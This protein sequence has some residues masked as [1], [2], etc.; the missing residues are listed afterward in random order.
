MQNKRM[1]LWKQE[2]GRYTSRDTKYQICGVSQYKYLMYNEETI[3]N[4]RMINTIA[5]WLGF[6][7]FCH[8]QNEQ[9]C[10][11]M[12]MLIGFTIVTYFT[13]LL[14]TVCVR[15]KDD[16]V[17]KSTCFSCRRPRVHS[18]CQHRCSQ[19]SRSGDLLSSSGILKHC[20]CMVHW[21]TCRQNTSYTHMKVNCKIK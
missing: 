6:S 12:D 18:Q 1:V 20:V 21:Y 9:A 10:Q 14:K 2:M 11:M 7:C 13:V 3:L 15:D 5:K 4:N 16:S 8:I 17:I 19:L